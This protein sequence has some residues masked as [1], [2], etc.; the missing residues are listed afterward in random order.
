M[1]SLVVFLQSNQYKLSE[2]LFSSNWFKWTNLFFYEEQSN[3]STI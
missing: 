2:I 3:R 1:Q